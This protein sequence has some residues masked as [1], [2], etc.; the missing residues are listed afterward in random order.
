[1]LLSL[2]EENVDVVPLKGIQ[3]EQ[4]QDSVQADPMQWNEVILYDI[5][6]KVR[7]HI[8]VFSACIKYGICSHALD[9]LAITMCD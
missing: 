9:I 1:M 7:L 2:T 5:L 6:D 4:L 3:R 8:N